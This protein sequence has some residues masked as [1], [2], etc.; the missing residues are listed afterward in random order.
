[1]LPLVWKPQEPRL[2]AGPRGG[3]VSWAAVYRAMIGLGSALLDKPR[4]SRGQTVDSG[5]EPS[6]GRIRG[7]RQGVALLPVVPLK[8]VLQ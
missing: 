5:G 2:L 4:G 3:G 8:V 7:G 1:M 6:G